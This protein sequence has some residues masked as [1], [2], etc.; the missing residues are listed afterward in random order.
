LFLQSIIKNENYYSSRNIVCLCLL[1]ILDCVNQNIDFDE[2]ILDGKLILKK[3]K[4][5]FSTKKLQKK[6]RNEFNFGRTAFYK[7]V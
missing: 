6:T 4:A 3:F 1:F 5:K 2:E 7:L